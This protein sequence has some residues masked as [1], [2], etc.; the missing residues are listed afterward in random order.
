MAAWVVFWLSHLAISERVTVL[1][2]QVRLHGDIDGSLL[3]RA[4]YASSWFRASH[5][6]TV[7][8]THPSVCVCV[9]NL[10][11]CFWFG[12]VWGKSIKKL[13]WCDKFDMGKIME[14]PPVGKAAPSSCWHPNRSNRAAAP[15]Q[16]CGEG[17]DMLGPLWRKSGAQIILLPGHTCLIS[18]LC[19]SYI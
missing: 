6:H 10:F 11:E 16:S 7:T 15:R 4:I 13:I 12:N 9:L 8:H 18:G 3:A 2:L 17:G 14:N 1:K 19:I 5:T